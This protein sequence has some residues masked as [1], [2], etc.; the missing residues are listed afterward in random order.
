M[1]NLPWQRIIGKCQKSVIRLAMGHLYVVGVEMLYFYVDPAVLFS[2]N[3][4]FANC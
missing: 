1:Y 2:I 4:I 3:N